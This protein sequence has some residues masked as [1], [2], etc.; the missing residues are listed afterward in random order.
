MKMKH[1]LLPITIGLFSSMLVVSL[2]FLSMNSGVV[3]VAY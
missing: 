3:E 2:I 1:L